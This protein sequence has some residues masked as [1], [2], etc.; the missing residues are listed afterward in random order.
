MALKK[1]VAKLDEY[2][3]RLKH[4]KAKRI[5]AKHVDQ[6]LDKLHAKHKSLQEEIHAA[7]KPGKKH[8]LKQKKKVIEG[9]IDRAEF[10]R[11]EVRKSG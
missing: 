5:K 9:Q 2:L 6:V 10:L 11:K 7:K 3:H 8:R 1:T 4:R